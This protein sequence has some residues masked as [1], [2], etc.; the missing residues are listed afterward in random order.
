MYQAGKKELTTTKVLLTK[1][2]AQS[3]QQRAEQMINV[4]N[5]ALYGT[6][7]QGEKFF[8]FALTTQ[9]FASLLCRVATE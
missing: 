6:S 1:I 3:A 7:N 4:L 5:S 9:F 2:P 8:S